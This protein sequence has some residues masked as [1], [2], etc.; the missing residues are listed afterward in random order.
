MIRNT[1]WYDVLRSILTATV[2]DCVEEAMLYASAFITTPN[3][4]SPSTLTSF[5]LKP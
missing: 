4:P 3:S 5:R 1:S 2:D